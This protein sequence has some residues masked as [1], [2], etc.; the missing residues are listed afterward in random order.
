MPAIA[1]AAG[2]GVGSIY[3]QFP[4]KRDLLAALVID[5]LQ[6]VEAAARAAL[7]SGEEPWAALVELIW[8][9]AA[10]QSEDGVVAEAMSCV[11]VEA[12]VEATRAQTN[13]ALGRLL[14]AARET[15]GLRADATVADLRI[16]F[17]GA[18]AAEKVEP[19]GWRRMVELGID[20][21]ERR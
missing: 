7:S 15:G 4:S 5:R 16:L 14:D 1:A 17:A 10:R 20:S 13:V 11:M 18:R 9:F 2:V 19:G 3:R 8:N 6:E 21:L 12:D